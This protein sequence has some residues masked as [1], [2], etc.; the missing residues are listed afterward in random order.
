MDKRHRIKK[1]VINVRALESVFRV[2]I[3]LYIEP[4]DDFVEELKVND[5][6]GD[7]INDSNF[8]L[9][10]F[11]RTNYPRFSVYWDVPFS[12]KKVH[13]YQFKNFK[14][15]YN[16]EIENVLTNS[17]FTAMNLKSDDNGLRFLSNFI[18]NLF[19]INNE[20]V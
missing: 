12:D 9:I 19:E 18:I 5:F 17:S 13:K 11:R 8:L 10:D 14:N 15:D 6:V 1:S 16:K 3:E 2:N 4:Y 7:G 20:E